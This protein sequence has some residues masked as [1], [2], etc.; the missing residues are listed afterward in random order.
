MCGIAGHFGYLSE[1]ALERML[2]RIQ[3][4]G[5]DGCGTLIEPGIG[6]GAVRLAIRDPSTGAQPLRRGASCL[7]YNGELY[8]TDSLKRDLAAAGLTP[9]GHSDTELILLG[10]EAWG[11]DVFARLRGMFALVLWDGA[12]LH[13][14][15]DPCGMKPLFLTVQG[16]LLVFASEVGAVLA[17]DALEPRLHTEALVA[18]QVFGH[19]LGETTLFR[20]IEQVAPG[21]RLEVRRTDSGLH[22][23]SHR[24]APS[25]GSLT[26]D[27]PVTADQA[28]A[29]L[30]AAVARHLV[31]DVPVGLYLSGGMDSTAVAALSPSPLPGFV[32][33]E[34]PDGADQRAA[35]RVA[36]TLGAACSTV[37]IR[38]ADPGDTLL[39]GVLAAAG[40]TMPSLA[41]LSAPRVQRSVGVAL[42]GDGSDEV[43]CG[44][45]A[46][47]APDPHVQTFQE[48][49]RPLV[50]ALH[51]TSCAPA[52]ERVAS[53]RAG[54]VAAR[55][56]SL[57]RFF[58][59]ELLPNKHLPI[60]D[61]G[62]MAAG[63]E[64]R[65]PFLDAE[66]LALARPSEG[67]ETKP[68]IRSLLRQLLPDD[69]V[70]PL[71]TRPKVAATSALARTR[72][73]LGAWCGE[74]MAGHQRRHPA[75]FLGPRPEELV[76]LD[77]F[78]LSFMLYRGAPPRDVPVDALLRSHRQ[79]LDELWHQELS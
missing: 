51:P 24:F 48:R 4:R 34:G 8:G 17:S 10:Y 11:A 3:P 47:V 43:F 30:S 66:V 61:R 64:V 31:A 5:P 73:A 7:V 77:L 6:L 54:N 16:D 29:A 26:D 68:I 46:H 45:G 35:H 2:D 60:W 52:L 12:T 21:V 69:V 59:D 62:S 75:R 28:R 74:H 41:L 55:R 42:C 49:L 53:L 22:V 20:G 40:P 32:V 70:V 19:V 14:A 9:E 57:R 23:R 37:R 71:L 44:Y 33:G 38:L 36:S 15:R 78:L 72:R 58:L 76:L 1:G 50:D 18:Q 39:R 56:E 67:I 79:A 13:L 25:P 63:L 27:E 65:L